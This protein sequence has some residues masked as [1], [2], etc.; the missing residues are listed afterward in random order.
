MEVDI[1]ICRYSMPGESGYDV[2]DVAESNGDTP[3]EYLLSKL[4]EVIDETL[5]DHKIGE[6]ADGWTVEGD[7]VSCTIMRE[8]SGIITHCFEFAISGHHKV[9]H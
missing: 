4:H 8:D 2:I 5:R 1:L 7:D 6:Y 9:N 3:N